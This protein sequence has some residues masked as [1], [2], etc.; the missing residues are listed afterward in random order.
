MVENRDV[1]TT[2]FF[3]PP[4]DSQWSL[5]LTRFADATRARWPHAV[6]TREES[7]NGEPYVSFWVPEDRHDGILAEDENLIYR[8]KSPGEAAE[9]IEWFLTLLPEDARIRFSSEIAVESGIHD[10]WWLT[11]DAGRQQITEALTDHLTAVLA[12]NS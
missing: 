8:D 12:G 5:S 7:Y 9:F 4:A 10:D 2:F 3:A 1:S 6:A 11:R